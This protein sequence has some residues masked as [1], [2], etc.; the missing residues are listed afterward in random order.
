MDKLLNNLGPVFSLLIIA[1]FAFYAWNWWEDTYQPT[2]DRIEVLEVREASLQASID[3]NRRVVAAIGIDEIVEALGILEDQVGQ[4]AR[5]VPDE[6]NRVDPLPLATSLSDRFNVHIINISAG[7]EI[8][9][10][11][12]F[13]GFSF[14]FSIVG[15]YHDVAAFMTE[16]L[17]LDV[18]TQLRDIRL[19]TT[20]SLPGN[21]V[22]STSR[23]GEVGSPGEG[24]GVQADFTFISFAFRDGAM[25]QFEI[26]IPWDDIV[27]AGISG[28][29]IDLQISISED[30]EGG[31]E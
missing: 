13:V 6:R 24:W 1:G 12:P 3:G 9:A 21:L 18:I 30:G 4:V 29:E 16:L 11:D 17:S 27:G 5:L 8:P 10:I 20:S 14:D 19:E 25:G 15:R 23:L 26:E 31:L 2:L 7:R 22:G 28:E